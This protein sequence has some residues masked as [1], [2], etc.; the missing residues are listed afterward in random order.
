MDTR[1]ALLAGAPHLVAVAP[2]VAVL[3]LERDR[4][5]EPLASHF[6]LSGAAN[7]F[8]GRG[9]LLLIVSAL[10]VGLALVFGLTARRDVPRSAPASRVD[11]GRWFVGL[12]WATAGFLGVLLFAATAAN[13]DL[14]DAATAVLPIWTFP[15]GILACLAAGALGR[16]LA[17]RTG[18]AGDPPPVPAVPLGSTEQVSWSRRVG[19]IRL[20]L[21]GTAL[22]AAGPVLGVAVRPAAGLVTA[23][24][25]IAVVLFSSARVVVDGRGLT[26]ALGPF[27]RPHL[28]IPAE[29]ITSA[30]VADISP[31][32]FG[33]W[34]YRIVPGGRGVI[35]RSGP[36]L[37]VT[38]R[39]GTRFTV[40]VDDPQTA[41]GVLVAIANR[42][43]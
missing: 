11:M 25:G 6:T 42:A 31:I 29:D 35:V 22:M 28:R 40:T 39:S 3:V 8:A 16:T 19:S 4:L 34:G 14:A 33:G 2:T 12:S 30:T 1:R 41:A 20:A 37:V 38:R 23:A 9:A 21:L 13:L 10:A 7:G 43:R 32:E 17:P 24:A 27:G 26:V 5:P 36:A 15:V 18:T